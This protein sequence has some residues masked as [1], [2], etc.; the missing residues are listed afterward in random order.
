RAKLSDPH[1]NSLGA[2]LLKAPVL[3]SSS[4]GR[5]GAIAFGGS[6]HARIELASVN[7][8]ILDGKRMA[9]VK[10]MPKTISLAD[11]HAD[12]IRFSPG[13]D[14]QTRQAT[15]FALTAHLLYNIGPAVAI[16]IVI[17][18]LLLRQN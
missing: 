18:D 14:L 15:R 9:I 3:R 10:R 16:G 1:G 13:I 7:P 17:I 12:L 8:V 2:C 5:T 11:L 6:G 4:R